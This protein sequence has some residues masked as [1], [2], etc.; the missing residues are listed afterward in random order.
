MRFFEGY[1]TQDIYSA[2]VFHGIDHFCRFFAVKDLM[3]YNP[4]KT[5]W[6][7]PHTAVRVRVK[8]LMRQSL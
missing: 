8:N 2:E 1:I 4:L 3:S 5:V 7:D 6:A